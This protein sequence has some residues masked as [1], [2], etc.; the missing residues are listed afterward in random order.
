MMTCPCFS[1]R[2]LDARLKAGLAL[3]ALALWCGACHSEAEL[4]AGGASP[5]LQ[6]AVT[7]Q[8][9]HAHGFV[10]VELVRDGVPDEATHLGAR[11]FRLSPERSVRHIGLLLTGDLA[12]QAE[13]IVSWRARVGEGA[14]TPWQRA[15][16]TW[17]EGELLVGRVAL[18]QRA[19]ELE[20]KL[21]ERLSQARVELFETPRARHEALARDLPMAS[22]AELSSGEPHLTRSQA[23]APRELVIPRAEWG[24]RNPAKICGN[25]MTPYRV[26]VHHTAQPD[27]DGGNSAA[28]M[29]QMQAYHIDSNGW[30]DIGYHFVVSQSGKIYQGR[31][32]ERRPG[33]HV[34]NQN[35]GNIGVSFIGNYQADQP[36]TAQI[37]A[38]QRIL[39]WIRETYSITW[40]TAHVKGHRQW[41]GQNT[42]CPGSNLLA[43][44]PELMQGASPPP[45]EPPQVEVEVNLLQ[46]E[47]LLDRLALGS[48]A[49]VL[50]P[51]QGASFQAELVIANRSKQAIRGVKLGYVIEQPYLR[52]ATYTIQSDAPAFNRQ[53]WQTN[54]SDAAEENPA[55]DA[56]GSGGELTLYAMAAGETKRVLLD[57]VA[58][59]ESLGLIDHPD[60]RVFVRHIDGVY[61]G[62]SEWGAEPTLNLTAG[63][64]EAMAQVDVLATDAWRFDAG[65]AEQTEG[66]ETCGGELSV[67]IA[68]GALKLPGQGGCATS[69]PWT[70]VDA[71]RW[72]QLVLRAL[73]LEAET[74]LKLKWAEDAEAL[75]QA[76][77][78]Y[79]TLPAL[80]GEQDVVLDLSQRESWQGEIGALRVEA[81][82]AVA[83]EVAIDAI[84]MQ[85]ATEPVSSSP[86]EPYAEATPMPFE[87]KAPV[88]VVEPGESSDPKSSGTPGVTPDQKEASEPSSTTTST[89]TC[90]AAAPAR[91][92]GAGPLGLLSAAWM[93][94]GA[95]LVR[96]RR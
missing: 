64:L 47:A 63:R 44:L 62:Q 70:R 19:E 61:E 1:T 74:T 5:L 57:L 11:H 6:P 45:P 36:P 33:A 18:D 27:N 42:S 69:P 91:A 41:P 13:G 54:D 56:L 78:I 30:C 8:E 94:L 88:D 46:S 9:V 81:L 2:S 87:L 77:P 37:E 71:E 58:E 92:R 65:E 60:V 68:Q 84:Y 4:D 55:R 38:G 86:V 67:D 39:A 35:G 72:P 32:D 22:S 59:Q 34:A 73:S 10:S 90:S 66:W 28:R 25:V 52:A 24:A 95:F 96:R 29:R 48:S 89:S 12:E 50:D 43:K 31:S 53:S 7:E 51:L 21:D 3:C 83:S 14:W 93:L 40:D 49:G 23:L 79:I 75:K 76:E 80:T 85:S 16:I 82:G 15:E 20:F 26:S 17:R